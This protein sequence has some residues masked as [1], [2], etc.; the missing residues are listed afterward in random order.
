MSVWGEQGDFVLGKYDVHVSEKDSRKKDF[1]SVKLSRN[2]AVWAG[3]HKEKILVEKT[4]EIGSGKS[5]AEKKKA[6]V[7]VLYRITNQSKESGGW[8]VVCPRI[9]FFF[10][11]ARQGNRCP[12]YKIKMLDESRSSS[13]LENI[14]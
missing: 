2:G 6:S 3:E 14:S 9:Q 8:I 5:S 10:F 1:V 13:F 4:I 7:Q 11:C 12:F